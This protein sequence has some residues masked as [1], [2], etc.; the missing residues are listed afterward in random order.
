MKEHNHVRKLRRMLAQGH[1]S[2]VMR[3]GT[4]SSIDVAHDA[5]CRLLRKG[6]RC[7]CDPEIRVAWSLE[8]HSQN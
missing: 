2:E 8:P 1:L 5:W 6:Q 3:P 4:V 7:N